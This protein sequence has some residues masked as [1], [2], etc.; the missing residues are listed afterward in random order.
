[1]VFVS[2]LARLLYALCSMPFARAFPIPHSQFRIQEPLTFSPSH[3]LPSVF[4]PLISVICFPKFRIQNSA[5]QRLC[6]PK[7]RIP[8]SEF[9]IPTPLFS[10]IQNS[11]FRIPHSNASVFQNSEFRIQNSVFQRLCHPKFLIPHS[12]FRIQEPLTFLPSLL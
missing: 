4:C 7:L 10:K 2:L 5:F 8:H 3:L 12:A 9:R 1:M 11:A 6:F